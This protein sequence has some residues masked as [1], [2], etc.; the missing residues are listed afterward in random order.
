MIPREKPPS[1]LDWCPDAALNERLRI[2]HLE[3]A[4]AAER[5]G[6]TERAAF[7][8]VSAAE[9]RRLRDSY[10]RRADRR[11]AGYRARHGRW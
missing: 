7:W 1:G 9:Q 11:T 8:R 6:D 5:S 10:Q 3:H 2:E 4:E